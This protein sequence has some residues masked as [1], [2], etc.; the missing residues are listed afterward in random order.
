[1]NEAAAME[2]LKGLSVF[3][4]LQRSALTLHSWSWWLQGL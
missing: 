3:S 2:T 4:D 1:M